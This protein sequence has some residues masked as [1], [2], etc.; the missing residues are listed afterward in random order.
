MCIIDRAYTGQVNAREA[1]NRTARDWEDV[2][3]RIGREDQIKS[4][5]EAIGYT[6]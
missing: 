5:Q 3:N 6:P 1:L 4:Y 2:T